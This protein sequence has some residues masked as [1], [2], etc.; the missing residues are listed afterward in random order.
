[1][2]EEVT[3]PRSTT[4]ISLI[5]LEPQEI[6]NFDLERDTSPKTVRTYVQLLNN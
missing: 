3:S 2:S 5:R 1:M 4:E 6:I